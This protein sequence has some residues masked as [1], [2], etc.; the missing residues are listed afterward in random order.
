MSNYLPCHNLPVAKTLST[1]TWRVS[2]L[3]S[4]PTGILGSGDF[5]ERI[6]AEAEEKQ[7]RLLTGVS[8]LKKVEET[9]GSM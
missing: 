8:A 2:R 6:V 5:V 7:N 3:R 9:I 1:E 4:V